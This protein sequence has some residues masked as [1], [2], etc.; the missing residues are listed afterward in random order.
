[1]IDVFSYTQNLSD[2]K[3]KSE[4][5]LADVFSRLHKVVCTTAAVIKLVEKQKH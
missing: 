1:M 4:K 5:C 2:M 3:L